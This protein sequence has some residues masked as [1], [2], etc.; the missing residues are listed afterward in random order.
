MG[1]WGVVFEVIETAQTEV[2]VAAPPSLC[3]SPT[4]RRFSRATQRL[5]S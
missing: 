5:H 4:K 3:Y 1:N 2:A